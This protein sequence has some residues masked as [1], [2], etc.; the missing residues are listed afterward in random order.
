MAAFSN[1]PSPTWRMGDEIRMVAALTSWSDENTLFNAFSPG[2]GAAENNIKLVARV[3]SLPLL[4]DTVKQ[5]DANVVL[6]DHQLGRGLDSGE[7]LVQIIQKLR[8]TPEHPIVVIGVCSEP[9]W[10]KTFEEAGALGTID[11]PLTADQLLRFVSQLAS[12]LLRA[13]EERNNP[14]YVARF[15]EGAMRAIDS[16]VWQRRTLTYWSTKGGVG[17]SW[18]SIETAVALGVLCDRRTVLIDADMNCGDIATALQLR[19][20]KNI[21]GLATVFAAN[22]NTLTPLMLQQHLTPYRG[23]LQVLVGAYAMKIAGA[24]VVNGQQGATF[25]Q[26]L[27]NTLAQMGFDFVVWDLGQSF[28]HPLHL[29]PLLT[30]DLNLVVVTPDKSTLV[31]MELALPD[32]KKDVEI[33]SERF[34]LVIN[35]WSDAM[36][37]SPRE[38]VQRLGM[39]EFARIPYGTNQRVDLALQHSKP[40]VLDTPNEVSNAIIGLVKGLYR[41][42]ELIWQAKGGDG[43]KKGWFRKK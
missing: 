13:Y 28:H 32:L 1:S 33:S 6:L 26:A 38:I 29:T 39:P 15:S 30:S 42:V 25:A 9:A 23:N 7:L 2:P 24:D 41:P 34:R 37:I 16:G 12:A 21:F 20:D 4:L 17:K 11:L 43:K 40:L 3:N 14:N 8:H 31:E 18:L 22:R 36:G 10:H 27:V 19:V 35:R 5:Y